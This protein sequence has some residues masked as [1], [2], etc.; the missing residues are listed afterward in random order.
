MVL[1]VFESWLIIFLGGFYSHKLDFFR[2]C[3][4]LCLLVT[5]NDDESWTTYIDLLCKAILDDRNEEDVNFC[6][7]A[8]CPKSRR[9]LANDIRKSFRSIIKLSYWIFIDREWSQARE[10]FV[11]L[12]KVVEKEEVGEDFL[13]KVSV[14]WLVQWLRLKLSSFSA[15][16]CWLQ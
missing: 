1:L 12:L 15:D 9:K 8:K 2:V 6:V 4:A 16:I 7:A 3:G 10:L 11:G 14:H 5:E 13:S